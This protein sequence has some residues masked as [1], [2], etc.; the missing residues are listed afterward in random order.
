[1]A[2][3][4]FVVSIESVLFFLIGIAI[5]GFSAPFAI[6]PLFP[7]MR[8]SLNKENKSSGNVINTL[9][10]LYNAAL[11]IGAIIGPLVGA[12]LYY[13]FE[14]STTAY[15]LGNVCIVLSFVLFCTGG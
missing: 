13:Y 2:F 14:F 8:N 9:A 4:F 5:L 6:L 10:G 15:I 7:M 1:M 11:G 12:N 3:G